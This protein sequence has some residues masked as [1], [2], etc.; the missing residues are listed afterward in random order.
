MFQFCFDS[1]RCKLIIQKLKTAIV[2]VGRLKP[3]ITGG[4]GVLAK[5]IFFHLYPRFAQLAQSTDRN[6]YR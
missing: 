5:M 2:V 6:V 3:E 4:G 1:Q